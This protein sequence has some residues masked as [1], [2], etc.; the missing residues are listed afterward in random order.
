MKSSFFTPGATVLFMGT[1]SQAEHAGEEIPREGITLEF[2]FSSHPACERAL[3]IARKHPSCRELGEGANRRVRVHYQWTE[4][5]QL[6]EFRNAA[7][8]LRHKR[9]FLEGQEIQWE[10]MAQVTWCFEE[11]INRQKEQ[12][13]FFDENFVNPWGCR[14]A[15]AHLD[16]RVNHEWLAFGRLDGDGVFHFDRE[17]I[18][19]WVNQHLQAGYHHCPAFDAEFTEMV[20]E[21]FPEKINPEEDRRWRRVQKSGQPPEASGSGVVPSGVENAWKITRELQQAVRARRGPAS[22][23]ATGKRPLPPVFGAEKPVGSP[24]KRSL[25]AK[26]FGR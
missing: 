13:C 5:S 16:A 12:H 15:T 22:L 4:L 10:T 1:P 9:A 26:L 25:F 19:Q 20:M 14:Y 6:R 17:R 23:L 8:E 18:R 7:W 21:I 11:R 24:Q 3:A 2:A